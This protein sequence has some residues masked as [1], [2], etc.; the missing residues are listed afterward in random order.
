MSI[1]A[2]IL[3]VEDDITLGFI[4]TENLQRRDYQIFHCENGNEAW[5]LFRKQPFDLC[6]LDVMLPDLD[7]FSLAK[8]IRNINQDIPILFVTA[9]SLQE[10]KIEGLTLG[11]DDYIV[12]PFSIEELVLRI[13]IFLRRSKIAEERETTLAPL[14]QIGKYTLDFDNLLLLHESD[15]IKLTFREAELIKYF[16]KNNGKLLT[17]EQILFSVWGENDY[18]SGRSLDVFISRL[19]KYFKSDPDISIEN[20]HGIG[21]V[22]K[23]CKL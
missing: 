22:F 13:E 15:E 19:R 5:E 4:T 23:T 2:K 21:F 7:G 12:K 14:H 16:C 9:K 17:R 18:F 6:I 10:D 20:R 11:A 3:Y 8:R 1:A